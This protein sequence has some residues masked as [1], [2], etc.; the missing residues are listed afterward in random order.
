MKSIGLAAVSLGLLAAAVAGSGPAARGATYLPSEQVSAAFARG[1]PLVEVEN[2]KVHASRRE[3]PG[4]VEIHLKDTDII[5]V[6]TGTATF[7]TG[8]A[9]VGG[10]NVEPE[11]IRGTSV[12][13]GET[14]TIRPGDVIIVPN[15]TPHWFKA[16]PAPMTYYVVK[17]RAAG[18]AR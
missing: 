9:I 12:E 14:R 8:G 1:M 7:V 17:V 15:G 5:H 2:Y 13:G 18:D 10:R 6:L 16:V 4:Q 3:A 11:E